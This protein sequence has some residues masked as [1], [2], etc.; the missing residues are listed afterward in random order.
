MPPA[1]VWHV[2]KHNPTFKWPITSQSLSIESIYLATE[3]FPPAVF[4]TRTFT[5]MSS[6]SFIALPQFSYP[7]P[8]SPPSPTEPPWTITPFAPKV[9]A[10]LHVSFN[11]FLLGWRTLLLGVATFMRYGAWTYMFPLKSCKISISSL[12]FGLFHIWGLDINIWKV[13][14]FL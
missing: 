4:S 12:G 5:P 1:Q 11:S 14:P 3:F 6:T 7:C 9:A 2:S 10:T 8:I 13:S